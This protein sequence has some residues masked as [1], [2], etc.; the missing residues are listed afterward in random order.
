[1]LIIV[2]IIYKETVEILKNENDEKCKR[3]L[4]KVNE[5]YCNPIHSLNRPFEKFE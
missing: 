5:E 4:N 2:K 3:L 1:M